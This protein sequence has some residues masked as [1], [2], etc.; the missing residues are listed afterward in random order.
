[1]VN[2]HPQLIFGH[3]VAQQHR[4]RLRGRIVGGTAQQQAQLR[5]QLRQRQRRGRRACSWHRRG[6]RGDRSTRHS[7]GRRGSRP[8]RGSGRGRLAGTLRHEARQHRADFLDG[9]QHHVAFA[10]T[11][12]AAVIR[13]QAAYFQQLP[14][15]LHGIGL[16]LLQHAEQARQQAGCNRRGCGNHLIHVA[17]AALRL[18]ARDQARQNGLHGLAALLLLLQQKLHELILPRWRCS[19]WHRR[20]CR[21]R[22]RIGTLDGGRDA[23]RLRAADPLRAAPAAH[24]V[25]PAAVFIAQLFEQLDARDAGR[26]HR[27]QKRITAQ[28]TTGRAMHR[29]EP[30]FTAAQVFKD[31]FERIGLDAGREREQIGLRAVIVAGLRAGLR[32]GCERGNGWIFRGTGHGFSRRLA[33]ISGRWQR[34]TDCTTHAA[35]HRG[36]PS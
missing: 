3:Q 36:P 21:Y 23:D 34:R 20:R 25:I 12:A 14:Q 29:N 2:Q 35:A 31:G 8:T 15:L 28:A 9:R 10:G 32:A 13:D 19:C 7:E 5:A 24:A 26:R 22:Y 6:R 27:E 4:V 17:A 16:A 33:G 11:A 1:M 18:R 30:A